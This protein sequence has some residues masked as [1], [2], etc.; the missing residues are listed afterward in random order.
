MAKKEEH[1][2]YLV[3]PDTSHVDLVHADDLEAKRAAGWKQPTNHKPNGQPYNHEDDFEGQ[4]AAA[5]GA[6]K[7]AAAKADKAAKKQKEADAAQRDAE[8]ARKDVPE[9]A[10][11]KVEVI[12][13]K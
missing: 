9:H 4:D 3:N 7:T 12:K 6:K 8:K 1:A 11:F 13:G 2:L 5:E 10:D